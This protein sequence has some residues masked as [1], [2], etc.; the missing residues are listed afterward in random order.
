MGKLEAIKYVISNGHR[1]SEW[2]EASLLCL[3]A[4]VT[5]SEEELFTKEWLD[6]EIE[7]AYLGA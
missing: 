5:F 3:V 1:S 4:K 6:A 7:E 2:E